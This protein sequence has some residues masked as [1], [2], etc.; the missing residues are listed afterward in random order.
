[1]IEILLAMAIM[2]TLAAVVI[3][4]FI[5][6]RTTIEIE[7][8]IN[9]MRSLLRSAQGRAIALEDNSQWG[10]RFSNPAAEAPFYELFAGAAYPGTIKEKVFLSPRFKFTSPASGANQDVVFLKRSGKTTAGGSITVTI[11]PLG[12]DTPVRSLV[13]TT[14]GTIQ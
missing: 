4:P 5:G 12:A 8:E 14:E 9:H 7:E 10:V 1:M 13:V 11:Q 2:V 6:S 3:A